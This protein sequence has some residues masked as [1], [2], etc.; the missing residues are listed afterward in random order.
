MTTRIAF[1]S[2]VI[3][4]IALSVFPARGQ[5]PAAAVRTGVTFF[6]RIGAS[7]AAREVLKGVARDSSLAKS[8]LEALGVRVESE[9]AAVHQWQSLSDAQLGAA[10]THD[11][12][13]TNKYLGS[14][15]FRSDDREMWHSAINTIRSKPLDPGMFKTP[16]NPIPLPAVDPNTGVPCNSRCRTLLRDYGKYSVGGAAVSS[17]VPLSAY[18]E[19]LVKRQNAEETEKK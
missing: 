18:V 19:A 7:P 5:A 15:R 10:I 14:E 8:V 1:M 4:F 17:T 11:Q 16:P 9:A 2:V 6:E 3:V 12:L 13:L